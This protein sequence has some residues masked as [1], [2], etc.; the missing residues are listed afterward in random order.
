MF[1]FRSKESGGHEIAETENKNM[2]IAEGFRNS[3]DRF[4]S[5]TQMYKEQG[6]N[7]KEILD[8][9]VNERHILFRSSEELGN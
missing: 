3:T 6:F 8:K 4:D 1:G 2:A 5:R 7:N 9:L